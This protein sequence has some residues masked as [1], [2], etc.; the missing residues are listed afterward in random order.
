M[1]YYIVSGLLLMF[2]WCPYMAINVNVQY[3]GGFLPD[4]ILWTQCYL[5]RGTCLNAMK[6]FC[7]CSLL[8]P[9]KRFDI[10]SP[11]T[12][13]C[14]EGLGVVWFFFKQTV[15]PLQV[16]MDQNNFIS[17]MIIL[18]LLHYTFSMPTSH[19]QYNSGW[20]RKERR[21]LIGPWWPA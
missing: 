17:F 7:I 13:G 6:W 12:G 2:F 18:L 19:H 21:I 16:T 11:I 14:S 20:C 15:V 8:I 9:P 10:S 1:V 3:N 5:H 4:I